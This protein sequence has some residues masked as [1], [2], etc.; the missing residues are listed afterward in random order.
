M[1]DF[2]LRVVFNIILLFTDYV[3]GGELFTHLSNKKIFTEEEVRIYIGEI[4]LALE[5]L[6][7]MG[8]IY[9]DIKL[10]NILLDSEGHIVLTDFGLSKEFSASDTLRR[11]YSY[12]GT[13][14]YMAPEIIS[15]EYKGVKG[16]D[17]SVD[18]W[19][20]G[21]LAYELLSGGSPF[22]LERD[23][24]SCPPKEIAREY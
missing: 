6:H 20:V 9:R 7:K 1:N 21:V 23:Q 8:I 5:I 18:W 16:H 13:I 15:G 24:R 22:T 2:D 4:V 14:E 19:S 12:C 3:N 10:E 17:Q 11:A